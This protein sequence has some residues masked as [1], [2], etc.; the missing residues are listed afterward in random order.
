[1]TAEFNGVHDDAMLLRLAELTVNILII[2]LWPF[3]GN[4][5]IHFCCDA[6]LPVSD[7]I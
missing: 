1:M 2:K 5:R 3:S 7:T 4:F 6:L